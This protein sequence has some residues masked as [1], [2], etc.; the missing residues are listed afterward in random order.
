MVTLLTNNHVLYS[1][2]T[3]I[4]SKSLALAST[5]MCAKCKHDII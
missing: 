3:A 2:F 1:H 4:G 5:S